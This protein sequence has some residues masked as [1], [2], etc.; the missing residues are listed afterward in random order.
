MD[1]FLPWAN[2][3]LMEQVDEELPVNWNDLGQRSPSV[4][5]LALE[6]IRF[7]DVNIHWKHKALC[8]A[9]TVIAG[10]QKI[11]DKD[12]NSLDLRLR[13][14]SFLEMKLKG[15]SYAIKRIE[16]KRQKESRGK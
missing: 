15:G 14:E 13:T 3:M 10:Q 12:F 7:F 9:L 8:E 16:S 6:L 4:K 2:A 1:Q 5:S 11:E